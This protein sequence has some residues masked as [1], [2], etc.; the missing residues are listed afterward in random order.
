MNERANAADGKQND[1][2]DTVI[3]RTRLMIKTRGS[4]NRRGTARRS[5]PLEDFVQLVDG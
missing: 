2:A 5:V 4:A 3:K 1:S